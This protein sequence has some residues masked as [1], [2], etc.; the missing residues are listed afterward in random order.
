MLKFFIVTTKR[1]IHV[2]LIL[3]KVTKKFHN[4][5]IRKLTKLISKHLIKDKTAKHIC[6]NDK[7]II[8]QKICEIVE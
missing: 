8:I 4:C 7:D 5:C 1:D 2:K 3:I 6:V